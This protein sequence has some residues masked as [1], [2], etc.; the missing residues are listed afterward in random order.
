MSQV[1]LCDFIIRNNCEL[2]GTVYLD[3]NAWGNHYYRQ[4]DEYI[5]SISSKHKRDLFRTDSQELELYRKDPSPFRSKYYVV[6]G[7]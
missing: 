2:T 5:N 1:P 6:K 3:E 7:L 4:L